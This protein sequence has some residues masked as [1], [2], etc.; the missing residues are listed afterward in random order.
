MYG[1][2]LIFLR[3]YKKEI[4]SLVYLFFVGSAFGA[5][6]IFYGK[7]GTAGINTAEASVIVEN[8][9]IVEL[10][11]AE[12]EKPVALV[13]K[14]KQAWQ[15]YAVN[16]DGAQ[17]GPQISIVIDDLGVVKGRTLEVIKLDA[18][19]TLSFLP[20]AQDLPTITQAARASGHELMVH[21]PMEPK[22]DK[23]PGPHAL[24]TGVADEKILQELMFNLSQFDGYVGVN[25]HMGSAFTED[26]RGLDLILDEVRNRGLLVLDSRT[27]QNSLLAKMATDRDIPNITRDVFLDNEQDVAYI[28]G[29]L[30]KL[31]KMAQRRGNAIAIGHPYKETIQA[32]ALWLPT[33]KQKGIV[34]VPLSHLIKRKYHKI[35]MAQERS[36]SGGQAS[37]VH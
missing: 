28:L 8:P 36:Q 6:W 4:L 10:V 11:M 18:P 37:S 7:Q 35:Q 9:R 14:A 34:V 15:T 27:S 20:Y 24:L 25:N 26:P 13:D 12:A 32:L 5:I 30:D 23:D 33:L 29:Q 1:A 19:L 21:L 22:G 16:M 31:E 17:D 3:V 2:G